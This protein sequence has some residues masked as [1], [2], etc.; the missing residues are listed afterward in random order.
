MVYDKATR[1]VCFPNFN[2]DERTDYSF[3]NR[4]DKDHHKNKSLI[5]ELR[6]AD[7]TPMVDM[8]KQFPVSDSLHL[9]DQGVMKKTIITWLNG[10]KSKNKKKK[11]GQNKLWNY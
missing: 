5:E 11:N 3:R 1:R 8:V 9:L 10:T 4:L 2:G 7:G 6:K